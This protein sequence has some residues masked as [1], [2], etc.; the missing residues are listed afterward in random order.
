MAK[1]SFHAKFHNF[2]S[3]GRVRGC[4]RFTAIQTQFLEVIQQMA[5]DIWQ[6]PP[7]LPMN[8]LGEGSVVSKCGSWFQSRKER[9]SE[10]WMISSPL[11]KDHR[12]EPRSVFLGY[13]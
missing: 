11:E 1:L 6:C 12:C 2:L 13:K 7:R 5:G 10:V 3:T 8:A 4:L 9:V